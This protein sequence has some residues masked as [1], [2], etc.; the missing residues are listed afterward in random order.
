MLVQQQNNGVDSGLYSKGFA[1]SLAFGE[2]P[3]NSTNDS[4]VLQP[5]LIKC[6]ISG[7]TA[8]FPKIE[9]KREVKVYHTINDRRCEKIPITVFREIRK[10]GFAVDSKN[11]NA[12]KKKDYI[13]YTFR[14]I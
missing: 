12:E 5:H 14:R 7:T 10:R 4:A 1:T 8:P 13:D 6:L 3:S 2:D 9:G 11:R